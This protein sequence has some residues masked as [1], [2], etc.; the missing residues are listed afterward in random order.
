MYNRIKNLRYMYIYTHT[1]VRTYIPTYI[2]GS[3]RWQARV[4]D[5]F[6]RPRCVSNIIRLL[7]IG[8]Y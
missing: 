4:N 8:P 7:L 1:Y 2:Y 5:N 3:M 6:K